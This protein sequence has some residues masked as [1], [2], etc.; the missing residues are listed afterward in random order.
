MSLQATRVLAASAIALL[1]PIRA[2]EPE[3]IDRALAGQYFEEAVTLSAGDGGRLWGVSLTGPL[4][5][6][7]P[8][9]RAVAANQADRGSHLRREG[10]IDVGA[11]PDGETIANSSRGPALR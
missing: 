4:L 7:D 11:L 5:F 8:Q 1:L 10:P 3:V 6:V 9:T 2:S